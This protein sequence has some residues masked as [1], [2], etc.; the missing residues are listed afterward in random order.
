MA[1][2][3]NVLSGLSQ[4][5]VSILLAAAHAA[6]APYQPLANSIA[7]K[8]K[9]ATSDSETVRAERG[10]IWD[11]FKKALDIAKAQHHNASAMATGLELACKEAGIP[12]GTF[13]SYVAT[14]KSMAEEI[15]SGV[16]PSGTDKDD[17]PLVALTAETAVKLPIMDARKRYQS[18]E[19]K[20]LREARGKLARVTAKWSAEFVDD[21]ANIA[22]AME[23]AA[24]SKGRPVQDG[25][26][27]PAD[28][29]DLVAA[30]EE[31][32]KIAA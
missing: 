6:A 29:L 16:A 17:K 12:A 25:E 22:Q 10:N 7:A 13:R 31:K 23:T 20:A 14:L 26:V 2:S 1:R 19:D 15:E 18:D 28:P 27:A 11:G 3:N 21:L 32:F 30:F 9:E 8:V 24:A 5:S 4:A